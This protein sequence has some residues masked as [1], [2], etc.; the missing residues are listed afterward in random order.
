M[1]STFI[2]EGP[3]ALRMQRLRAAREGA[4]GRAILTLPLVA[5]WLTGGFAAPAGPDVLHPGFEQA[6][7]AGAF[8]RLDRWRCCPEW[9]APSFSRSMRH[10]A[11]MSICRR[12]HLTSDDSQISSLSNRGFEHLFRVH[13]CCHVICET[14]RWSGSRLRALSSAQ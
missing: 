9:R 14:R 6:L 3:L 7:T 13:A 2:V 1:R 12:F 11:L 4:I 5:A 8:G 10:G